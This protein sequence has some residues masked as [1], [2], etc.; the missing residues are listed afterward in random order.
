MQHGACFFTDLSIT[1]IEGRWW[2]LNKPLAFYSAILD[3][4]LCA[5]TCFV[6]DGVSRP[7]MNRPTA[8]SCIHDLAYRGLPISYI[9]GDRVFN[10]AMKVEGRALPMRWIKTAV[11]FTVGWAFK[12]NLP[13]CLDPRHCERKPHCI[14]CDKFYGKWD[15]CYVEGYHPEL[16]REHV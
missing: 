6:F 8:A 16:W 9:D 3:A 7:I 15:R 12:K 2:R 4:T 1:H 13:G 11:L 14:Y 10:E 5:P